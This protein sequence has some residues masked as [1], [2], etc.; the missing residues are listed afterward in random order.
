M[1]FV[2]SIVGV[3]AM[4]LVVGVII[5]GIVA[6]VVVAAFVILLLRLILPLS[7]L[8]SPVRQFAGGPVGDNFQECDRGYMVS[9]FSG[10][11]WFG[12]HTFF[13]R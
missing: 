11:T 10:V 13:Q 4:F 8:L 2:T 1:H 5:H 7:V 3:I 9:V 6:V 12:T